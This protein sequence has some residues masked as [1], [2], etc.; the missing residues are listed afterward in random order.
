MGHLNSIPLVKFIRSRLAMHSG[1]TYPISQ[2]I[3]RLTSRIRKL[4]RIVLLDFP[5]FLS[6]IPPYDMDHY[7]N[8]WSETNHQS[9]FRRGRRSKTCTWTPAKF[10]LPRWTPLALLS[11]SGPNCFPICLLPI[12]TLKS[13]WWERQSR[14]WRQRRARRSVWG[15]TWWSKEQWWART[16]SNY[17]HRCTL[18]WLCDCYVDHWDKSSENSHQNSDDIR[19]P[20]R[21]TVDLP[22]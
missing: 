3:K 21:N 7:Q 15:W 5:P 18:T 17:T 11:P 1:L 14:R 4:N 12:F 20:E 13:P 6:H 19:T 16:W 9:P 22:Y 10:A 8:K 2:G